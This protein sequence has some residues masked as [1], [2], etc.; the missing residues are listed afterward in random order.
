MS[1]ENTSFLKQQIDPNA[2]RGAAAA[3]STGSSTSFHQ[4]NIASYDSLASASKQAYETQKRINF[5]P[6]NAGIAEHTNFYATHDTDPPP[7][8]AGLDPIVDIELKSVVSAS[9]LALHYFRKSPDAKDK[10]LV[11]TA[12][13][14]GLY[15]SYYSPTYTATKHGVIGLMR[16]IARY[17]WFRN[18]IRVNAICPSVVRANFA[19]HEGVGEFHGRTGVL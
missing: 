19:G 7:P 5:V 14:G 11:M 13:C 3:S 8:V 9:Y 15:P 16:S 17:F 6:A 18:K 1:F 2:E 12:S 10:F 4:T